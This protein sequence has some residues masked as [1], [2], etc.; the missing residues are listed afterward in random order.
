LRRVDAF[1]AQAVRLTSGWLKRRSLLTLLIAADLLAFWVWS[2]RPT[3]V[4]SGWLGLVAYPEASPMNRLLAWTREE[5]APRTPSGCY[6]LFET[7]ELLF[8]GVL[9]IALVLL[10]VLLAGTRHGSRLGFLL[11]SSVR[12]PRRVSIRFRVTTALVATAILALYLGWEINAWRTWRLR[13]A[14]QARAA[15][16]AS[17]E[18]ISQ[19]IMQSRQGALARLESDPLPLTD[20]SQPEYGYYR[21]RA[22]LAA[23]RAV[24]IDTWKREIRYQS[25]MAEAHAA[26]KRKYEWAAAHPLAPVAAD[27]PFPTREPDANDGLARGDYA[28]ALYAYEKQIQGYPDYVEAHEQRAW[29]Y[30]TCPDARYRDGP[31]AVAS[32]TRACEL[33]NWKDT[34]AL[35]FLAVAFAESGDFAEAVKWQE[36]VVAL[37]SDP[38]NANVARERLTLFK[39]GK[40]FRQKSRSTL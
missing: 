21:S 4:Y 1:E 13:T 39:S 20:F 5:N 25:V 10:V 15:R 30:A 38:R 7:Q 2:A 24:A 9:L 14:F 32:A 40:P 26:Q 35:T 18:Q 27:T 36:K 6:S 17:D 19:N 34:G 22:A 31:R 29:I 37:T 16:A 3:G 33:T 12:L 23:S 28:R 8:V 11:A